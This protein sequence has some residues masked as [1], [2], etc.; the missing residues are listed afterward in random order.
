MYLDKLRQLIETERVLC[1][2]LILV[3]EVF[4]LLALILDRLT[5]GQGESVE[6][7]RVY[8]KPDSGGSR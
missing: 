3:R 5:T 1:F 4:S 2:Y 7:G 6:D 8:S